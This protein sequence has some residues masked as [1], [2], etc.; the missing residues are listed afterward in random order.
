M[1]SS[2]YVVGQKLQIR[3]ADDGIFD[4][5]IEHLYEPYSMSVV[6][7]ISFPSTRP[8]ALESTQ[9]TTLIMKLYD[10]RFASSMRAWH[11]AEEPYTPEIEHTLLQHLLHSPPEIEELEQDYDDLEERLYTEEES[12]W[13]DEDAETVKWPGLSQ[14]AIARVMQ[15]RSMQMADNEEKVYKRMQP[16]QESGRIPRYFCRAELV[17]E[18]NLE[19]PDK[20]SDEQAARVKEYFCIPAALMSFVTGTCLTKIHNTAPA[21]DWKYI[22]HQAMQAVNDFGDYDVLNTDVST[23]DIIIQT[24]NSGYHH[25]YKAVAVDLAQCRLRRYDESD[26]DWKEAKC[27]GDEETQIGLPMYKELELGKYHYPGPGQARYEDGNF[28]LPTTENDDSDAVA[29]AAELEGTPQ[30]V[31]AEGDKSNVDEPHLDT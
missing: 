18:N 26:D 20:L 4:V 9:D 1:A 28:V 3:L 8:A 17:W 12:F 30:A 29:E 21:A 13:K 10:R 27:N 6:A 2:P 7:R 24:I 19:L 22:V 5:N 15:K 25:T 11:K 31:G 16:L 14:P 23:D